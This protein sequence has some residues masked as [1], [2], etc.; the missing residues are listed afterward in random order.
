MLD[1][2][3]DGGCIFDGFFIVAILIGI[4]V[5]IYNIVTYFIA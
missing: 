5:G 4:G 3:G 2:L 1:D